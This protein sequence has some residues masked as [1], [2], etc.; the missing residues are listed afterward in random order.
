MLISHKHK[1]IIIDIEKTGSRSW[2]E[3]LTSI[4]VLDVVGQPQSQSHN[5]GLS[6]HA[7][8]YQV[9]SALEHIGV[10]W[11][12]YNISARVRNPWHRI[13]SMVQWLYH[14]SLSDDSFRNIKRVF[15]DY[16]PLNVARGLVYGNNFIPQYSY[17]HD[18][19][20]NRLVSDVYKFES[21]AEEFKIFCDKVKI[22]DSIPLPCANKSKHILKE[23]DIYDKELI[24]VIAIKE[25]W[26]IDKF[27]Y[28]F[29][30]S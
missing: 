13:R 17:L 27:N 4:D 25:R 20:G 22:A 6:Q 26:V 30:G 21:I 14:K 24:D 28:T 16:G 10:N 19:N 1:F 11:R 23:S 9:V 18:K 15:D 3:A 7:T 8:A 12:D 2:R 5:K 29:K